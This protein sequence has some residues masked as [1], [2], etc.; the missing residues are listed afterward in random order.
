MK[1]LLLFFII[2]LLAVGLGLL[3]HNHPAYLYISIGHTHVQTSLWLATAALIITIFLVL[4]FIHL[5]RGIYHIPG[6]IQR[7]NEQ[8]REKKSSTLTHKGLCAL[9]EERWDDCEAYFCKSVK[10]QDNPLFYYLGAA[11]AAFAQNKQEQAEKYLNKAQEFAGSS[12]I[13]VIEVMRA[14]WQLL[15]KDYQQAL[16][17]LTLLQKISPNHPFV[18]NGLKE[19][20]VA[21]Q[22]WQGLYALLPK[23]RHHT[24]IDVKAL[25]TLEQQVLTVLLNQ[26]GQSKSFSSSL[27]GF[28]KAT[29]KK[30]R[31]EP[32]I[33]AIYIKYLIEQ[34]QH[35]KAEKILK[36]VLKKRREAVLLEEYTRI[37]SAD[38]IK[39]LAR[40]ELWLKEDQRNPD[41]LFCL[42]S[43]CARHR[44]WGKA[45]T[46]LEASLRYKPR[47]EV[48]PILGQVLEQLDE[49]QAA[50]DCYKAGVN[51]LAGEHSLLH[52]YPATKSFAV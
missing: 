23:L 22:N 50:L 24:T 42:G 6:K 33:L 39:Q 52:H 31:E 47:S 1:K 20:Y 46:Y 25:D 18:L 2:L 30:W 29:P 41:L 21:S 7:L 38:S 9:L 10:K 43:L 26:A 16:D 27:E 11:Y 5:L 51:F 19:V 14:R 28:W 34:N 37:N 40:A 4:Q 45:K 13:I 3:I 17:R 36:G 35:E 15:E 48:Y 8:R 12:E 44:L 32:A 49:K